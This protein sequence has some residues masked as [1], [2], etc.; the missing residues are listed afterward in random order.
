M[1]LVTCEVRGA[2][3]ST[4][5]LGA[6]L[7]ESVIVDLGAA[8]ASLAA[9]GQA[10]GPL[11]DDMLEFLTVGEAALTSADAALAHARTVLGDRPPATVPAT[12]W[13]RLAWP[14]EKLRLLPA[15]PRPGKII[16]TSINFRAHREEVARGFKS[17]DWKEIDW[18]A[19]HYRHPTGFL[20]APSATVGTD[21]KIV[22]PRFTRQLD[23]ELEIAIVIGRR[24]RNVS[25][26]EALDSVAGFCIFNDIS[27]RDMQASEHTNRVILLGK[28]FDGSCPLGPWLTTRDE[29]GDPH[30]L[31]MQ[32]RLNGELR[33]DSNTSD[34]IFG[35]DELVSWWSQITLEPGDIITSGSPPGVIAG[36]DDPVWLSAGDR[37]E[38]TIEGLG[39]LTNVI[40]GELDVSRTRP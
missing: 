10:V 37:L 27:A 21:A 25:K 9:R 38:A 3:A 2:P 35:I 33:Q 36:M 8:H 18:S 4:R 31:R 30:N 28:S 29:I 23:Y 6:L 26:E 1:K 11:P 15:V 7:S 22:I 13:G 40:V 16:H 12:D 39:T 32:L 17:K 14:R 5:F 34:M 19:F 20:Q 24:S